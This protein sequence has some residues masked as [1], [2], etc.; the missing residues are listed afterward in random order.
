MNT[1]LLRSPRATGGSGSVSALR[2]DSRGTGVAPGADGGGVR[3]RDAAVRCS[4][5]CTV[6][7][8]SSSTRIRPVGGRSEQGDDND[9]T[10]PCWMTESAV[11]RRSICLTGD[12]IRRGT[13]VRVSPIPYH[14]CP[15]SMSAWDHRSPGKPPWR[16]TPPAGVRSR[17]ELHRRLHLLALLRGTGNERARTHP[18]HQ[19][20]GE[21]ERRAER[22]HCVVDDTR[23][24]S[25]LAPKY[26][27]QLGGG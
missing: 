18:E 26:V 15:T 13:R 12:D 24:E 17:R 9:A 3:E 6:R 1:L 10:Y 16:T 5:V 23:A 22:W 7:K 14:S 20:G 25:R 2:A 11:V 4:A 21:E 8:A 27:A 19:A